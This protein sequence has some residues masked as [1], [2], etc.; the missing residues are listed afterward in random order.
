V[1]LNTIASSFGCL[2]TMVAR[3]HKHLVEF[4]GL[5]VRVRALVQRRTNPSY[6]RALDAGWFVSGPD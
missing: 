6:L 4:V 1:E 3:M 5:Q 2:S